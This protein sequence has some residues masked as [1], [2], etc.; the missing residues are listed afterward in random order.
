MGV[1][2][3]SASTF[4]TIQS[5][6]RSPSRYYVN[7]LDNIKAVFQEIDPVPHWISDIK[8]DIEYNCL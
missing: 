2:K 8:C 7:C 4:G 3:V 1:N 6:D 5:C